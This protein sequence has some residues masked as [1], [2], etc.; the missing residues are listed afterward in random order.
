M[1]TL[2]ASKLEKDVKKAIVSKKPSLFLGGLCED[3]SWREEIKKEFSDKFCILDPYDKNWKA[4]DN[5]YDELAGLVNA[6]YIVF[7]KGGE[8]TKKEKS[9][10]D[11]IQETSS[12]KEFEDMA[13]LKDYI[14][15]IAIP[16]V[17]KMASEYIRSI[18]AKLGET[19]DFSSTQVDLPEDIAK[20]IIIWSEKNIPDSILYKDRDGGKGREN[21]IHITALYGI[22]DE[23]KNNVEDIIKSLKIKPF[24]VQL[25]TITAFKDDKNYDVLKIDV[26][27]PELQKLHYILEKEV[28][29]ENTHKS[30]HPHVTIAYIKKDAANKFIG[31]D[32]FRGKNFK[33][34]DIT[35]SSK[36]NEKVKIKLG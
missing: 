17:K 9:F 21:E 8:G 34:K 6:D 3:N 23:F 25:G 32:T 12:Y 20:K 19:Y 4:E 27:S 26:D 18:V 5:I 31:D 2:I 13:K 28:D 22:T 36:N 10:L 35:F 16:I 29:N 30:Y 7:Y 24:D 11:K 15:S 33:A 1:F 14:K